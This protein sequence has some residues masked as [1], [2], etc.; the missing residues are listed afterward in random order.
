M[1][2]QRRCF[3]QLNNR[4]QAAKTGYITISVLLCILGAVLIAVPDFSAK[5]ICR[6]IGGIMVLFGVIKII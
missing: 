3:V 6:I 5:L 1:D 2:R 4:I